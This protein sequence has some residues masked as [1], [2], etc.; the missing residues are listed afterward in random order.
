M[1]RMT[2]LMLCHRIPY[3]ADKGD[4]IRNLHL[5]RAL[6]QVADVTVGCFIDSRFD[7]QYEKQLASEIKELF[8]IYRPPQAGMV[9]AL[10]S[11]FNGHAITTAWYSDSRMQAWVAQKIR[12]ND[13]V[14]VTSSA[15]VQYCLK[16][17]LP[18]Y[19]VVD[20]VDVD[21]DKWLQ[22]S[23][24]SAWFSRW[25]F[26]REAKLIAQIETRAAE[27][28]DA[29]TF[30][31]EKE[32]DFFRNYH[33]EI[34]ST[35]IYGVSNG[36]D[37]SYFSPAQMASNKLVIGQIIFTGEMNYKP[38]V[39]AVIWF[40]TQVWPSILHHL[41]HA[42][43]VIVGRNPTAAIQS[44]HG[45][46]KIHVT[47]RVDDVRPWLDN[48]ALVIA[49]MLLARGIKNKVLEAMAMAKPL[50]VTEEAM[51]GLQ[52][53]PTSNALIIANS[54]VEFA[55]ACIHLLSR[56]KAHIQSHRDYVQ[57]NFSWQHRLAPIFSLL[58]LDADGRQ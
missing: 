4:K 7:L 25:L 50:V 48:S 12:E 1:A 55:E 54:A 17:R 8:C 35:K 29:V 43:F 11:F 13:R 27:H 26:R 38:N 5:L 31:S 39:E 33:P 22:Y 2:V 53:L 52:H 40:V 30:V 45:H 23:K 16:K 3:P 19:S 36:V 46:Q 20:L 56:D 44:F 32:A 57:N 47:G 21:S 42:S 37:C 10:K 24:S 41:P 9:H 34:D 6:Q 49:P 15:M 28:F 51:L 14:L 18:S 58:K